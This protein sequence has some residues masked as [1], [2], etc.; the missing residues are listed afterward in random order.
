MLPGARIRSI[1][2][3]L[4]QHSHHWSCSEVLSDGSHFEGYVLVTKDN[5]FMIRESDSRDTGEV[6]LN[7]LLNSIIKI[8]SKKKHPELITF[9][10]GHVVKLPV[11][12][13]TSKTQNDGSGAMGDKDGDAGEE[14]AAEITHSDRFYVPTGSKEFVAC[15]K[16]FIDSKNNGE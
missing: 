14:T 9:K 15:V 5:L 2:Q 10:Y 11:S 13:E 12:G 8:T 16:K 7:R 6:S 1:K 4:K 3:F